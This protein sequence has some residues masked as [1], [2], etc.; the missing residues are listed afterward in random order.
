MVYRIDCAW[1][2]LVSVNDFEL[3]HPNDAVDSE[4]EDSKVKNDYCCFR[5]ERR[6]LRLFQPMWCEQL[7]P[8]WGHK[9]HG[10]Q[11]GKHKTIP[12][13][14]PSVHVFWA[15]SGP[16]NSWC[17]S[18][19]L[20]I[21]S[22]L[23]CIMYDTTGE[24]HGLCLGD[25]VYYNKDSILCRDNKS[26][27][28]ISPNSFV[29]GQVVGTSTTKDDGNKT[30]SFILVHFKY[31]IDDNPGNDNIDGFP[32][33]VHYLDQP[34]YNHFSTRTNSFIWLCKDVSDSELSN[35]AVLSFN[36]TRTKEQMFKDEM[37]E[38]YQ[39]DFLYN[40]DNQIIFKIDKI[41]TDN[42]KVR[43][44]C[45]SDINQ[46]QD[47]SPYE[48]KYMI[49]IEDKSDNVDLDDDLTVSDVLG[50]Y[51]QLSQPNRTFV[52]YLQKIIIMTIK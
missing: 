36:A 6:L 10:Q 13:L 18:R 49:K 23:H 26:N 17:Q 2:E 43:L 40:I 30:Y 44:I 11:A 22:D 14:G 19:I 46:V 12:T 42:G 3:Q 33:T 32:S 9:G 50:I 51:D 35:H 21:D 29:I 4:Y 25:H 1:D 39:Q 52:A 7:G 8:Y 31:Y 16:D 15:D 20:S 47:C 28:N 34:F 38:M 37:K 27:I 41:N 24:E 5:E 45:M 48:L